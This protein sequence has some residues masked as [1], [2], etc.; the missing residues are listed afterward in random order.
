MDVRGCGQGWINV[1]NR[2]VRPSRQ[3]SIGFIS[4]YK[5]QG[6]TKKKNNNK[7]EEY[8]PKNN[9]KQTKT[10]KLKTKQKQQLQ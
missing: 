6:L 7:E 4:L 8:P 10:K 9:N 3:Y 1:K 5:H 2:M